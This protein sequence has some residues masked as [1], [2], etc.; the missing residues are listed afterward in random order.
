MAD[1]VRAS[2]RWLQEFRRASG[3]T[4]GAPAVPPSGRANRRRDPRF[5]VFNAPAHLT[6]KGRATLLGLGRAEATAVALDLSEG[7]ARIAAPLEA[8]EGSPVEIRI[9]FAKFKDEINSGGVVSWCRSDPAEPSRFQLGVMFIGLDP[10]MRRKIGYIRQWFTSDYC[11]EYRGQKPPSEKT[12]AVPADLRGTSVRDPLSA[13]GE[14][15]EPGLWAMTVKGSL[16]GPDF[17]PLEKVMV[18]VLER[19]AQGLLIDLKAARARSPR[20]LEAFL[21]LVDELGRRG[22]KSLFVAVP[23]ALKEHFDGRS[24]RKRNFAP[25]LTIGKSL[26]APSRRPTPPE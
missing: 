5:L 15:L 24:D 4:E 19:R 12:I 2:S 14:E 17:D 9:E 21:H 13:Q 25:D 3:Q 22:V 6:V 8:S 20:G 16:E 26:L 7:G 10:S 11:A 1:D 23:P 18:R